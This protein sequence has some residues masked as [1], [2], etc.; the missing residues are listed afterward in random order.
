MLSQPAFRMS[1]AWLRPL[2][3]TSIS[4]SRSLFFAVSRATPLRRWMQSMVDSDVLLRE[5]LA[6][7]VQA[8]FDYAMS[9]Q[10][11]SAQSMKADSTGESSAAETTADSAAAV[12][13]E[14][15]V[16]QTKARKNKKAR[17]KANRAGAS[18]PV[19]L[20]RDSQEHSDPAF[21]FRTAYDNG[22]V[23][24]GVALANRLFDEGSKRSVSEAIELYEEAAEEGHPDACFNL[25][26]VHFQ[27]SPDAGLDVDLQKSLYYFKKGAAL[28]DPSSLY[29]LG[30]C[31]V[32]GEG[33]V[34][35]VDRELGVEYLSKAAQQQHPG[36]HYYLSMIYRNVENPSESDM[37]LFKNHL[38][39]AFDLGDADAAFCL[40]EV[41]MTGSDGFAV[42]YLLSREMLVEAV[43]RGH[44]EAA[45]SLGAI[46]YAGAMG[47]SKDRQKAF[48]LYSLAAD[49]G[50]QDA[51]KNIA[52][53]YAVGDGVE[54]SEDTAKY[55]MKTVFGNKMETRT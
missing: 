11:Q 41:Y 12:I 30:Y 33:G 20:A 22:H 21:W 18:I 46:Y 44:A 52:A 27:G 23:N 40:A 34:A 25:G 35:C 13:K 17:M 24:A 3:W 47:V 4:G 6:G 53:M 38:Q 32:S 45:M 37:I 10:K 51:W 55:I 48:Q 49:R 8:Q 9:L 31:Y 54:K 5:A 28:G 42:D 36:A 19:D 50:H 26:N 1:S 43:D 7:N 2:V 39:T 16:I 15:K 14:V 29:W